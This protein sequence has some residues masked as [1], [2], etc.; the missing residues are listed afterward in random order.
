MSGSRPVVRVL[1]CRSLACTMKE[2]SCPAGLPAM[3]PG[4]KAIDF[5]A[6]VLA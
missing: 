4:P 3:R 6:W 2:M 1:P 5:L